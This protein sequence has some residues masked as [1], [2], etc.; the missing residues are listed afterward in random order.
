[1][2]WKKN[3]PHNKDRK[4]KPGS[5]RRL[6][7]YLMHYKFTLLLV[8]AAGIIGSVFSV[9]SPMIM[10]SITTALFDGVQSGHI[11]LELIVV[12]LIILALLY[13]VGQV[14]SI[15]QSFGMARISSRMMQRLRN[16]VQQ[17][18]Q[19]MQLKDYDARNHGELLSVVTNDIDIISGAISQNLT[20]I[21][22]SLILAIGT[23]IMML[24]INGWLTLI[25]VLCVPVSLAASM[26]VLKTAQKSFARQQEQLGALNGCIEEMISAHNVVQAFSY[27][28]QASKE[29][30]SLNDALAKT[31]CKAETASG[32]MMPITSL[33]SNAG[34]ILSALL[35]CL[36]VLQ[37]CMQIGQVQSMLQYAM[38]F[39][40]PFTSMASL[41]GSFGSVQAAAKRVYDLLD[42]Q[43]ELPDPADAKTP[44][45]SAGA[46][47]FEHVRFGYDPAHPLMQDVS[48]QVCPGQK[49]AIV[50]PTG[51]GKTTLINLLMRFYDTNSG[52]IRIDGLSQQAMT[53]K[54]L[55]SH[56]GMVLQDTWLFEGTIRENLMYSNPDLTEEQMM[57]AARAASAD[58]FIRRLPD[59]YNFRLT[60]GG[61]NLSVGE[62]QLLTIARAMAAD[63]EIM[64]LDEATSNVDTFTEKKI[65][66]A[67][68][69]L[70]QGRTSFV[71]AHRLSTI[72]DADIILYMENGNILE[73]GNHEDLMA[74]NGKYA[75]LYNSQ[76]A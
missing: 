47:R 57:E 26:G 40:S 3:K 72:R 64:I 51:A 4:N 45:T 14:F 52:Q 34:Y 74:K 76:F 73:S 68:H 50:G 31:A 10:G 25:A 11:D 16:E 35:G 23:F 13:L 24:Q 58:E 49:A 54:T 75:Q 15:I 12:L 53:R 42:Y 65:Q 9:L 44:E 5:I 27:E 6:F 28:K 46:V 38:Q 55:R 30:A 43:E 8:L 69:K 41:A 20:Q 17:K 21:V 2:T 39:S 22:S 66:N 37:G 61:K 70:M 29:F 18:L 19:R 63:P 60:T 59:G 7:S 71:I 56:F 1:M 36:F 67:M 32:S 62:R 48:L 33:V